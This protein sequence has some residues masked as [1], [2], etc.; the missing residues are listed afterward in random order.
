MLTPA[1][2]T[3][4]ITSTDIANR[5]HSDMPRLKPEQTKQILHAIN[6]F[7]KAQE[8]GKCGDYHNSVTICASLTEDQDLKELA[9][10]LGTGRI[11]LTEWH[12]FCA[13]HIRRWTRLSYKPPHHILAKAIREVSAR[14]EAQPMPKF[15]A[16]WANYNRDLLWL[17]TLFK[18]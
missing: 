15:F 8:L 18:R 7:R 16:Q 12:S 11:E 1:Q 9:Q 14:K 5:A 13:S 10:A 4:A 2:A 17:D 3:T 6:F